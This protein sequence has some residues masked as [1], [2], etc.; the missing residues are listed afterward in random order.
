[1]CEPKEDLIVVGDNA[2]NISKTVSWD[3]SGT[4]AGTSVIM[5]KAFGP[6]TDPQ[7]T[8]FPYIE[9]SKTVSKNITVTEES[10]TRGNGGG[11]GGGGGDD[12]SDAPA[13]FRDLIANFRSSGIKTIEAL[14]KRVGSF[15]L[16]IL[17]F[18]AVIGII[19]AGM[20]YITASGDDKKAETGKK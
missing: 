19:I 17:G 8:T 10:T 15:S 14:V 20:K 12:G 11:G 5:A 9:S 2:N 7:D 13:D 4:P 3:T 1:G 18:L 16:M 6:K